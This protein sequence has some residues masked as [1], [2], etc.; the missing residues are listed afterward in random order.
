MIKALSYFF[1][2]WEESYRLICLASTD[3]AAALI[4]GSTYHSVLGTNKEFKKK[5]L[6]SLI[7]T[8]A[9]LQNVD[10]ILLIKLAW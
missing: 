3:A 7:A 2:K 10:Y 1:A 5:V 4:G 9:K 8:R 6:A